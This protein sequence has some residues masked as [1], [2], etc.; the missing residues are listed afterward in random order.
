MTMNNTES[1]A[2]SYNETRSVFYC[3]KSPQFIWD[4]N[5]TTSLKITLAV[6]T[7]CLSSHHSIKPLGDISI[8][9]EKGI[10]KEFI[11]SAV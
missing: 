8:E 1:L 4:L 11:H 10:E 6:T 2:N 3:P 9:V 5:H 7:I